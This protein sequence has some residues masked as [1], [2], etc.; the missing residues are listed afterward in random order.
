[1]MKRHIRAGG[2]WF[3]DRAA[4]RVMRSVFGVS[5]LRQQVHELRHEVE[6][7]K[8]EVQESRRLNR[9]VAELTD[10]VEEIL[11]PAADRDDERMRRALD[12]YAQTL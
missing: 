6:L 9:R 1:M 3:V 11:V 12:K 7:L 10:V 8:D 4:P 5:T 2:R